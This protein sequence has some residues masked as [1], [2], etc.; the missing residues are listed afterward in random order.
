MLPHPIRLPNGHL[1]HSMKITRLRV[2][3]DRSAEPRLLYMEV[4][5]GDVLVYEG[6]LDLACLSGGAGPALR[7]VEGGGRGGRPR[8]RPALRLV[9]AAEDSPPP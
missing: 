1:S 3:T 9:P 2:L 6:P 5:E 8:H 7:V 4:W